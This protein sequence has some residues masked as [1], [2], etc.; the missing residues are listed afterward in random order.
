MGMGPERTILRID[1]PRL[2]TVQVAGFVFY[3]LNQEILF[4]VAF[5]RAILEYQWIGNV[6]ASFGSW[7]WLFGP[8]VIILWWA[9]RRECS[10]PIA[11]VFAG[12]TFYCAYSL[13]YPVLT[14]FL[15]QLG[16]I[17]R[18][19]IWMMDNTPSLAAIYGI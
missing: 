16:Q 9:Y 7:T 4:S 11:L 18:F 8:G 19:P 15:C 3:H 12:L 13:Q 2:I 17:E 1:L 5:E 14:S 10:R 6:V